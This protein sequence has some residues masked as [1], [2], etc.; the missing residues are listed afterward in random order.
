MREAPD[1]RSKSGIHRLITALEEEVLLKDLN[2]KSNRNSE[3]A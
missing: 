2:R 1:L 3:N